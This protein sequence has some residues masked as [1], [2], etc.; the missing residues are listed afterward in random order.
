MPNETGQSVAYR[1]IAGGS[2]LYGRVA[3]KGG[4]PTQAGAADWLR[5]QGYWPGGLPD[6]TD[7]RVLLRQYARKRQLA[8]M[9]GRTST[10]LT[11]PRG[12]GAGLP[13]S[14]MAQ[15]FLLADIG[16]EPGGPGGG[17]AG[18]HPTSPAPPPGGPP[19]GRPPT[20]AGRPPVPG[21]ASPAAVSSSASLSRL[22]SGA[23][24]GRL[25]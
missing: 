5:E 22:F 13:T 6:I 8:G 16:E 14:D 18:V 20:G 4:L 24:A 11:G 25:W 1:L 9:R 19:T 7:E 15:A 10:F 23:G 21:S 3:G 17:V 2:S 12:L